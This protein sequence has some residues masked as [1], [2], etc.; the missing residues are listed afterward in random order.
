MLQAKLEWKNVISCFLFCHSMSIWVFA[1]QSHLCSL[2]YKLIC[3]W[4]VPRKPT[5]TLHRSESNH[6]HRDSIRANVWK[7]NVARVRVYFD[8]SIVAE[9]CSFG[10][11]LTFKGIFFSNRIGVRSLAMLVTHSVL[12]CKLHWCYHDVW[13]C[14]LKTCWGCYCCWC[15]Y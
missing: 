13:R 8:G 3:P 6:L 15:W 11:T 9:C 5:W 1:M 2:D 7:S 4:W 14:Q 10:R 12:F